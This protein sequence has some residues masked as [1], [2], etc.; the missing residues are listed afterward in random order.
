MGALKAAED[1]QKNH[2]KELTEIES[3]KAKLE[4]L[5]QGTFQSLK[6]GSTDQADPVELVSQLQT[7]FDLNETLAKTIP[8]ALG[9][10][11]ASRGP[12]DTIAI[13]HIQED[14]EKCLSA[15]N[16]S[17]HDTEKVKAEH[18]AQ[19]HAAHEAFKKAQEQQ[20]TSA[21]TFS[22]TR[23]EMEETQSL[24][25]D[26]KKSL[27]NMRKAQQQAEKKLQDTRNKLDAF[28]QGPYAIFAELRDRN[29]LEAGGNTTN[30]T[31]NEVVTSEADVPMVPAEV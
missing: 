30:S 7:L 22:N 3:K 27:N 15:W 16:A 5:F 1:R 24:L 6:E 26:A 12:F 28:R 19:V 20:M 18:V 2:A 14:I 25:A 13:Q 9:K 17:I 23:K 4:G 29:Q 10:E 11:P 21:D 8:S 31:A